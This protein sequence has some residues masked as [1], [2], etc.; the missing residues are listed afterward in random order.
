VPSS[1]WTGAISFGLVSIPVRLYPATESKSVHF[2]LLHKK[3]GSRIQEHYYCAEGGELL[4]WQDLVRGYPIGGGRCVALDH[5][6][7]AKVAT[8]SLHTIEIAE[9]VKLSEI[10]PILFQHTYFLAPDEIGAKP[11]ALLGKTIQE[12]GL[13]ARLT[14]REKEHACFL[15]CYDDAIALSV[16]FAADEVRSPAGLRGSEVEVD[17]DEL[18]AAAK[19]I[20][21]LTTKFSPGDLHRPVSR[22]LVGPHQ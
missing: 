22:S 14:L 8:K 10:D 13:V 18:A 20:E 16:L 9:F 5:E 21:A 15:R 1:I 2:N 17:P 3:D 12:S 19:L 6:D 7:F 4:D 11:F